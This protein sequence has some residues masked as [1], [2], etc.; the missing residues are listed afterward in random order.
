MAF[1]QYKSPV[2]YQAAIDAALGARKSAG[3]FENEADWNLYSQTYQQRRFDYGHKYLPTLLRISARA[4]AEYE[5]GPKPY[6][7]AFNLG[8]D[9][10]SLSAELPSEE[11]L[12]GFC[13]GQKQVYEL[14]FAKGR[15]LHC[16]PE[17]FPGYL[18]E[19]VAA[20]ANAQQ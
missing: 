9:V 11:V 1:F 8:F 2:C 12:S 16:Y 20:A 13:D 4:I 7:E 10:A 19:A 6:L 18:A 17:H 5:A 15:D 3:H 14:G